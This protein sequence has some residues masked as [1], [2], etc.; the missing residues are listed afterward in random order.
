MSETASKSEGQRKTEVPVK[1]KIRW[2]TFCK[3][4]AQEPGTNETTLIGILPALQIAAH[5]LPNLPDKT[6]FLPIP[7]WL[8]LSM[9]TQNT[10]SQPTHAEAEMVLSVN[11]QSHQQKIPIYVG[12]AETSSVLNIRVNTPHGIPLKA[13][14]QILV[15][16]FTY[17]GNKIGEIELPITVDITIAKNV[18]QVKT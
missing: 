6:I 13:G 4:I 10:G 8:H 16:A 15:A 1:L 2:G 14:L 3:S 11:G 9:V 18:P 5:V 12:V 17:N 7:L